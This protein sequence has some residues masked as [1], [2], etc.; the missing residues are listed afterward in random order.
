MTNIC[1]II[2]L[3]LYIAMHILHAVTQNST[4]SHSIDFGGDWI[5]FHIN[6]AAV[7]RDANPY[8]KNNESKLIR[9]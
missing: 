8:K 1:S 5:S 2:V 9:P 3:H 6:D 4:Y 7:Y